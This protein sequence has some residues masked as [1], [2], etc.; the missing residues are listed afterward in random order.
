MEIVF[1]FDRFTQRASRRR[2]KPLSE[3]S[4]LFLVRGK[5]RT[6]SIPPSSG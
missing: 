3:R 2:S 4:A 1:V 6:P 5:K